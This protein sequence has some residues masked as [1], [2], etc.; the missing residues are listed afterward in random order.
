MLQDEIKKTYSLEEIFEFK[1]IYCDK[2]VERV[3]RTIRE[4]VENK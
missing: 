2:M 3:M 4:Q 1:L